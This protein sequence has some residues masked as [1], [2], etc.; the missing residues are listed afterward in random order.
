MQGRRRIFECGDQGDGR[1]G[2]HSTCCARE[3]LQLKCL[4]IVAF[5]RTHAEYTWVEARGLGCHSQF[6][7]DG[8]P[9]YTHIQEDLF[10]RKESLSVH[11]GVRQEHHVFC[12]VSSTP[13]PLHSSP[14][15]PSHPSYP[16]CTRQLGRRSFSTL[17][18]FSFFSVLHPLHLSRYKRSLRQVK[19]RDRVSC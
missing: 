14:L 2:I 17:C 13:R 5:G 9:S 1:G 7:H 19:S 18:I 15:L 12:F 16:G 11:A 3:Y 4:R 8:L 10:P 6:L